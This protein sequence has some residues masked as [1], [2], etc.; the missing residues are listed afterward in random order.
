MPE[1]LAGRHK[2]EKVNNHL[3]K[4]Q[5]LCDTHFTCT[6][7]S[8]FW[9]ADANNL[10]HKTQEKIRPELKNNGAQLKQF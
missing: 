10:D 9:L 7:T 5:T 3:W 4:Q 6:G 1:V 2:Q 8:N